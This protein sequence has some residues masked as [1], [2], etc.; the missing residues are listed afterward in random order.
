MSPRPPLSRTSLRAAAFAVLD[1]P[2]R[3]LAKGLL[4]LH[5]GVW[6]GLMDRRRLDQLGERQYARWPRYRDPEY[7]RSG[8]WPWE[9]A[10]VESHFAGCGSVL[11]AATGGGREQLALA[12]RGVDTAGFDCLEALLPTC[13]ALLA[14]HGVED[15]VVLAPAS[16]VPPGLGRFDGALV[17]WGA[18]THIA[19]SERRVRFLGQLRRALPVGGPLLVSFMTRPADSPSYRAVVAVANLVRRLRLGGERA[20]IGDTLHDT[21]DHHFTRVEI[22][23]ELEAAGFELVQHDEEP[24]GHAVG[25]ARAA[26]ARP[27]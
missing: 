25:R 12:R 16:E 1:R 15:R 3:R 27:N 24:F 22:E 21:F 9:E 18:Y 14:E 7:N 23:A 2:V 10:V 5:Q 8:F 6:L 13:R 20:E 4:A 26:A 17:G 19:G 11:V